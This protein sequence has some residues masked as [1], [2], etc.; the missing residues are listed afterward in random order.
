MEVSSMA[1]VYDIITARIVEQLER[2]TVPWRKPWHG[3]DGAPKNAIS[4]KSYRG[5]NVLLLSCADYENPAWL[6]FKQAQELGGHV[7]KGEKGL[8]IVYWNWFEKI[9]AETGQ[10][11]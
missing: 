1:S 11:V 3:P 2:G 7:R 9:D 4:G 10:L 8:P 6:T 5:I